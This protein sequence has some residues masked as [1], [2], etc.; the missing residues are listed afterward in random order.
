ME[1]IAVISHIA[2]I[3]GVGSAALLKM[4]F[5][6]PSRNLFFISH[7][8][9]DLE[10]VERMLVPLFKKKTSL[11]IT[12]M[13]PGPKTAKIFKRIITR[14]KRSGG[15][16]IWL[17]HHFWSDKMLKEIASECDVAVVGENKEM[18]ATQLVQ[19][20]ASLNTPF[21]KDFAKMLYHIDLFIPTTNKRYNRVSEQ[22]KLGIDYFNMGESFG[23][24]QNNLRHIAS[25]IASGKLLDDKINAA[26]AKFKELNEKRIQ[27][28]L[29]ELYLI[30][31]KIA[32]GFTTHVDSTDG[33]TA[34]KQKTGFDIA[35]LVKSEHGHSSI[36]STVNDVVPLANALGGGGHPHAAGFQ[37]NTKEYNFFRSKADKERF[38]GKLVHA[39]QKLGL[40]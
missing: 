15:R 38:V 25:I 13:N 35:I 27:L 11:F 26:A 8:P 34:I 12:D 10:L 9:E 30:S 17:D 31:Y 28:M 19:R 39:A 24:K 22:Y 37:V 16:V 3:D 23:A 5:K 40:T 21:A 20:L 4:K 29:K 14:A 18:C 7:D 32:I 6:I 33:C 1:N 2:D 36:R